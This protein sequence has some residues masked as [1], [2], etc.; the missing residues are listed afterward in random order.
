MHHAMERGASLDA[1]EMGSDTMHGLAMADP[2]HGVNV[3]LGEERQRL[4]HSNSGT[5]YIAYKADRCTE[6]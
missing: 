2:G 5:C 1:T 4:R 6:Y 3:Y